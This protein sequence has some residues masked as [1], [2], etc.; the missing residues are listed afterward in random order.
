MSAQLSALA[1]AAACYPDDQKL[2]EKIKLYALVKL[3]GLDS[4]SLS[5]LAAAAA[6]YCFDD[7]TQKKVEAYLLSLLATNSDTGGTS[8]LRLTGAAPN[9]GLEAWDSVGQ[10]WVTLIQPGP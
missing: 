6:C 8:L 5:D 10:Q 9:F 1:A 2:A 7:T 4:M 3:A